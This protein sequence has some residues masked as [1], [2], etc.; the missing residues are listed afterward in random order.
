M[1]ADHEHDPLDSWLNQQVR[2]LPPPPGTFELIT[3]RARRRRIRKAVV[4]VVSAATVAAAVGIAVPVSMSLRLTGPSSSAGLAAGASAEPAS[5]GKQTLQ[6]AGKSVAPAQP[7]PSPTAS[8]SG[9]AR[10]AGGTGATPG[11]LPPDFQPY[12]VTWDSTSTGWILGPAGTAGHCANPDP[13]I[14]TSVARTDDGGQTWHGLPAPDTGGPMSAT[15]V[16]GLRFLNAAHGWAFGPELWSTDD[17]AKTW[18]QVNTGSASVTDLETAGGRAYALFG[19]CTPPAGR[20]GDT[21]AHC[22]SYTLM[23]AVAGTGTWTRVGGVPAGL[24]AGGSGTGSAL[25]VLTG[26]AGTTAATGYLAGPNGLLYAGPLDGSAWH[27][28]GKLPCQPGAAARSGLPGQLM[29][30][31]A[32]TAST[33][34]ARLALACAQPG[35]ADTV[36]YLSDD[37]GTSW[38]RQ[39]AGSGGTSPTGAPQSL[40]ALPDGTLILATE[41]STSGAGGIYRLPL[42][43]SGWQAAAGTGLPAAVGGFSY[44][45]MTSPLQGVALP[46]DAGLHEIWMTTDGGQTWQARAIQS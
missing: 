15:G 4:T 5:G 14:C 23:T 9:P 46:L 13:A 45:G 37:G 3:R 36:A 20:T 2:P 18:H 12:S 11:Y 35:V 38:T 42:G 39:S 30:A 40:A 16:T 24:A 21:I 32:G 7:G 17:G 43:A 27:P 28:V 10:T 25:I 33:G 22:T 1:R 6:G 34:A 19:D 29:L 26:P 8:A 31:G 41:S 44:V